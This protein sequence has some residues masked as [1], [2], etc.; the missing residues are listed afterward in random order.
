MIGNK[1]LITVVNSIKYIENQNSY[2]IF[3]VES[4]DIDA[5]G[6]PDCHACSPKLGIAIYQY[7][8]KWK[9]FSVNNNAAQFGSFG[10]TRI[11]EKDFRIVPITT[12]RFLITLKSSYMGQGYQTTTTSIFEVNPDYIMYKLGS[13]S[14][15]NIAYL[16]DFESGS[17][18][19]G[20]KVDGE[21]WEGDPFINTKTYPPTIKMLKSLKKCDSKTTTKK[22]SIDLVYDK[23][24]KSFINRAN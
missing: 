13:N 21:E 10:R 1:T 19:C 2:A 12:E 15:V 20:A 11:S 17:S 16:G 6:L 24:K 8:N 5:Q 14:T 3:L 22:E 18:E 7:S 9:L 23:T 4:R